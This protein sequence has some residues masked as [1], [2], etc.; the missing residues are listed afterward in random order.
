[1]PEISTAAILAAPH[2]D[3]KRASEPEPVSIDARLLRS[4]RTF[5]WKS[6]RRLRL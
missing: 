1:M 2:H 3:G 6:S 5:G 4:S